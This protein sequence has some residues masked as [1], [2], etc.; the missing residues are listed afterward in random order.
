MGNV[1]KAV[2]AFFSKNIPGMTINAIEYRPFDDGSIEMKVIFSFS[3]FTA[4]KNKVLG[5]EPE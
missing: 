1:E 4:L 5:I 2:R 3:S